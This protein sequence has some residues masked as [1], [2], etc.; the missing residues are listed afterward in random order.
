MNQINASNC[1]EVD[2]CAY[3]DSNLDFKYNIYA[4]VEEFS[5]YVKQTDSDESSQT[6]HDNK[7]ISHNNCNEKISKSSQTYS[8]P[9]YTITDFK[10]KP[11][12]LLHLTGLE[13]YDKFMLVLYSLGPGVYHLKYVQKHT[14]NLDVPN[15]LFLVLWKLRRYTSDLELAEHFNVP[16]CAVGNIFVTWILFMSKTWS[17]LDIWP[18]RELI[19]FYMPD[20]FKKY[21]P[22]TRLIV[23]GTEIKT[24]G[25]S[26]PDQG[27]ATSSYYENSPTMNVLIGGT[28][29]GLI[30]YFSPAYSGSTSDRQIIERSDL[31]KK[32][33]AGDTI[34]A[35]EGFSVQD[36]FEPYDVKIATPTPAVTGSLPHQTVMK[37]RKLSKRRVH[38]KRFIGLLKTFTILSKK[39]NHYYAHLTSEIVG[40]CVM[41][42][43]FKENSMK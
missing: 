9:R 5:S 10:D 12:S 29:G 38:V 37:D 11:K 34:L 15:Q 25:S 30:S 27:Q 41:L 24:D 39:L 6:P 36:L 8:V 7:Q 42:T 17:L 13:N 40:V 16:E 19:D 20:I 32:C 4:Y 33:Q 26:D 43:N 3:D 1:D 14:G 18:S 28:P 22:T 31:F 35:D 21:N 2:V 23:D